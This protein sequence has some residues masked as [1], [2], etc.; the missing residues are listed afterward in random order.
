MALA[1]APPVRAASITVNSSCSISDAIK[2]AEN[3]TATGG[4]AA[5]SGADTITLSQD[6]TL[7]EDPPLTSSDITIEGAGYSIS[8]DDKYRFFR[9]QRD[10]S[11]S[12]NNLTLKKGKGGNYYLMTASGDFRMSNSAL[13]ESVTDD[14]WALI[15]LGQAT[16]GKT[17]RFSNSTIVTPMDPD[18][19]AIN[20]ATNV[21]NDIYLDHVTIISRSYIGLFIGSNTA[22]QKVHLRNSLVGGTG[23]SE[24]W[25]NCYITGG[26]A[27]NETT[28]SL[29]RDN[30]CSPCRGGNPLPGAFTGS[31]GYYPIRED[32]PAN[33]IG[34]AGVC[35]SYPK[36]QAGENRPATACN[37]GSVEAEYDVPPNTI[38]GIVPT[39]PV[40]CDT[41]QSSP[42]RSAISW[43]PSTPTPIRRAY[44]TC[45]DFKGPRISVSGQNI[46]T[47]CQEVFTDHAI[48][49]TQIRAEGWIYA[50]DVWSY[51]GA[52]IQVCFDQP[53]KTILLDAAY[54][55]RRIVPLRATARRATLVLTW[56]APARSSCKPTTAQ[57]WPTRAGR[58]RPAWPNSMLLLNFRQTPGGPVKRVLRSGIK[59][60]A[61]RRTEHWD[62]C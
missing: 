13:V 18:V 1:L 8:G 48:G 25:W 59:L 28:G 19:S 21:V 52:G 20:V 22:A 10:G 4:C 5:G 58:F 3:D 11:L 39:G 61:L 51:L 33:N 43:S 40:A 26:G 47:Q 31:P 30:T 7:T 62:L 44:S 6:A 36:D 42:A 12:L 54:A 34:D 35:A 15:A 29:I 56:G 23:G 49:D 45:D 37:A 60:T 46:G 32:S 24:G 9:V 17:V 14:G 50:L 57:S 38:G 55:P 53:G 2:S 41:G 27:L 16:G